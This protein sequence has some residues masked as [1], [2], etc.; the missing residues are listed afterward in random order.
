LL[1]DWTILFIFSIP[2]LVKTKHKPIISPEQQALLDGVALRLIS[3]QERQRFDEQMVRGH[4]LHNVQIVGEQLRYVAEYQGQWVALMIWSAGA[5]KLKLR[6][7]WIGWTDRQKKRRLALVIN[8]S[9]FFIPEGYHVPNLAS[10][11]MK[12][13][14][15]RLS[16]DWQQVYGHGVLI[17][18]T[19]V[20][21]SR[22]QGTAYKASGWNLL[23]KTQGF[24]RSRKD[25]YQAHDRPKQLWVCEL[26]AGARTILRGRNLPAA[27]QACEAERPPDCPQSPEEL[28]RMR[29]FFN[30]LPEWRTRRCP[31]KLGSLVA[32]TVCAMLCK[33]CLGQRDLAAFAR[34]LTREQMKALGFPRDWSKRIHT[35]KVPSETTF[36]RLLRHLDNQALQRELLRWL[37][38]LLGKRDPT[39]DQV[40]VDGKELLNSQGAAVL[41]AYS[42]RSGRWLG[43]EPVVGGSNEIPTAQAL[44]KRVDLEGSLLTAD[45]MHTQTETGRIVVQERGGDYLFTVKGNQKG[46]ADNARELHQNLSRAFPPPALCAEL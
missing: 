33:V 5:Y 41:S 7:Q 34:N 16:E 39:G 42:V 2:G 10:K 45:A 15:R 23:G 43:S 27:C 3:P 22:F 8:N 28:V 37:D 46:V 29:R 1:G 30:G 17:A 13:V 12:L 35:Y 18:E 31:H 6:E 24:E 14:L 21:P 11:V 9:R 20:D 32:V 19:F 38:Q 25:F 4:Y 26:Q 40:S 36:A 44:L